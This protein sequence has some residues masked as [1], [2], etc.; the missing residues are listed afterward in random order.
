MVKNT[1]G[2]NKAKKQKRGGYKKREI[3]NEAI[4][5][6]MFG[7]VVEHRGGNHVTVLCSDNIERIGRLGGAVRKGPKIIAGLYVMVSLWEFETEQKNC[8]VLG[9]ANP[10]ADV[11]KIFKKNSPNNEDDV[12]EFMEEDSK[13]AEFHESTNMIKVTSKAGTK[14]NNEINFADSDTDT[15]TDTDADAVNKSN[16]NAN[17]NPKQFLGDVFEID[18]NKIYDSFNKLGVNDVEEEI[19]FDDI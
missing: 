9:I 19:N 4:D 11:R 10:P 3:I 17:S 7:L 2:G 12:F 5:G 8:D 6:Q 1:S 18:D 14:S 13:F 15:D 16:T